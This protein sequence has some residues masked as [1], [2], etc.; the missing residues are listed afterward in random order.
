MGSGA[1][2]L[3]K[4]TPALKT[5]A[6]QAAQKSLAKTKKPTRKKVKPA[7]KRRKSRFA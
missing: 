2:K 6:K 1:E 5:T 7:K 3:E 4:K